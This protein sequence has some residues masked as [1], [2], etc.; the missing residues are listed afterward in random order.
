MEKYGTTRQARDGDMIVFMRFVYWVTKNSD[1]HSEYVIILDFHCKNGNAKAPQCYIIHTYI[2]RL[3]TIITTK[4]KG[5]Y[6]LVLNIRREI[7]ALI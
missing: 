2:S 7:I 5:K 4:N 6:P 3:V 1:T